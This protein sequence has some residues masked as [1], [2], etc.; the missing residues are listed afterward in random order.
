M[1]SWENAHYPSTT[2]E[3]QLVALLVSFPWRLESQPEPEPH[4]NMGNSGTAV[5]AKSLNTHYHIF[6][7]L[8]FKNKKC[9]FNPVV[10]RDV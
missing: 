9:R 10:P 5:A 3:P 7:I 6:P 8:Q 4:L 1:W 2:T